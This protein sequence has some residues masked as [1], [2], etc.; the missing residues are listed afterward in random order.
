MNVTKKSKVCYTGHLFSRSHSNGL[1]G[2]WRIMT[3]SNRTALVLLLASLFGLLAF[4]IWW[5]LRRGVEEE[6]LLTTEKGTI[7]RFRIS[8]RPWSTPP[9]PGVPPA[10]S[11]T[12][13][14]LSDDLPRIL[15]IGPKTAALLNT[16]GITTFAQLADTHV[17]RLEEILGEAGLRLVD[18]Q[19]WPDQARLAAAGQW[20]ALAR[21]QEA[22]RRR[23]ASSQSAADS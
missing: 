10:P 8:G 7:S 11:E 13:P 23:R 12:T 21:Y 22:I 6:I 17:E 3:R 5:W 15:G 16:V 9:Q 14:P 1:E 4:L 2:G 19:T 20:D 18:P